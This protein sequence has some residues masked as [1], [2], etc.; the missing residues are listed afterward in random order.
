MKN[1][2]TP[3]QYR[4]KKY[5]HLKNGV[6]AKCTKTSEEDKSATPELKPSISSIAVIKEFGKEIVTLQ[7][8]AL[9]IWYCLVSLRVNSFQSWFNPS[10]EWM[11]PG[12]KQ[13]QSQLTNIF[14]LT[15]IMSLPIS[16]SGISS[17][18]LVHFWVQKC[19]FYAKNN[20]I[21]P[22]KCIL[23]PKNF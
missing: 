8:I 18:I 3:G 17:E 7:F 11:F 5:A 19:I 9:A 13:V 23:S 20:F 21:T 22:K 6:K 15:Y 4:V 10:L 14:G 12:Q 1:I 16:P 2:L